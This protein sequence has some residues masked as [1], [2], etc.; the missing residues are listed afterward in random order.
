MRETFVAVMMA[1][2]AL[3]A[4]AADPVEGLWKFNGDGATV[5]I[6][7]ST[8]A[9]GRLQMVWVDGPDMSVEPGHVVAFITP[10]ARAGV[11]DCVVSDDP[12]RTRHGHGGKKTFIM[13]LDADHASRLT[14]EAYSRSR[15]ISLWRMLPYLFRVSVGPAPKAPADLEGAVRLDGPPQF[16]VL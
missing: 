16:I 15:R 1:V 6:V 14:F 12:R 13:H 10:G 7:P 9:S 11:Y 2:A 3:C 5:R 4:A 8:D